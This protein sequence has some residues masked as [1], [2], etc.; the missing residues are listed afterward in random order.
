MADQDVQ[1]VLRSQEYFRLKRTVVSPGDIYELDESAKTVYMGPDS[2]IGEVQVTY[3]NPNEPNALET[4]IVSVNGPFVGR[5]D[6]LP[7][8]TLPSTGQPARILISP[9][10]IV[11]NAYVPPN[12]IAYRRFN[13][14]TL[15][16]LIVAVKP[17]NNVPQVRADRTLRYPSVPYRRHTNPP[18][19]TDGSTELLI[20]IY[21]RRMV[22]V[23]IVGNDVN[24]EFSLVTLQPG[25]P[26]VPRGIG[27]LYIQGTIPV[28]PF[29]R[30]AVIRASDAARVAN[31]F[32]AGG[33]PTGGWNE[34]DQPSVFELAGTPAPRGMADLLLVRLTDNGTSPL[35]TEKYVDVFVKTADRET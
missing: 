3:F 34:S 33:T 2:D 17:L 20:P 23:T 31:T 14:P 7:K 28:A 10:D 29:S 4:A 27:V 1:A 18:A 11:D 13:L 30:T 26:T 21:G 19:G 24:A 32:N 25:I 8:T 16:D 22:T 5:I 6:T 35:T 15:I 12:S 9:V